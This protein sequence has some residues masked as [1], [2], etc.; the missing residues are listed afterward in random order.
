MFS[1]VSMTLLA[2][3][4]PPSPPFSHTSDNAN[5]QLCP[6]QKS[7]TYASSSSLSDANLLSVTTTGTPNCC[8]FSICFSRLTIPDLSASIS[9]AA[10]SSFGT[11]PL[12]F[13][14]RT[15]ATSTA[16]SGLSPDIRHFISKN[17]SA[18]RSAPKPASVMQ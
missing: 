1:N 8:I 17:F 15:V 16:T 5:S 10:R 3:S 12:Y 14:A 9:G 7:L 11:P 2:S 6:I 4:M 18:P 13:N